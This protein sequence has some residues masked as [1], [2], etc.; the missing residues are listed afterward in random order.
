VSFSASTEESNYATQVYDMSSSASSVEMC[1]AEP[2]GSYTSGDSD[3]DTPYV[4]IDSDT[5]SENEKD[6]IVRLEIFEKLK[7][8]K[9]L[10]LFRILIFLIFSVGRFK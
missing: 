6:N 3:S 10:L 7:N 5:D 8:Q 9:N 2:E 1:S 4:D